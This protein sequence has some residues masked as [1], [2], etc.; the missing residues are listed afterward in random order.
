MW[1]KGC[2]FA[3]KKLHC[4]LSMGILS[5]LFGNKKTN[6]ADEQHKEQGERIVPPVLPTLMHD[7]SASLAKYVDKKIPV[8]II[9]ASSISLSLC[10]TSKPARRTKR[11]SITTKSISGGGTLPPTTTANS[12]TLTPKMW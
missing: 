10:R 2:N 4:I 7:E 5:K 12:R 3:L 8:L 9:G 6:E 1:N 11:A